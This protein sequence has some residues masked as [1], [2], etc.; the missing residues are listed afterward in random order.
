[1]K[2]TSLLRVPVLSVFTSLMLIVGTASAQTVQQRLD[3]VSAH[4]KQLKGLAARM[5]AGAKEKLSASAQHQ[6]RLALQW[7]QMQTGVNSAA[8]NT[9]LTGSR[10]HSDSGRLQGDQVSDPSTDLL[11]SRMAGFTQS[12]TSTAWCGSH[13]LV[14]FND[15][16]SFFETFPVPGIGLSFNGYSLSTDA[17][18]SFTDLGYLNPGPS[19]SNFLEGDPVAVCTDDKTFYQSSIFATATTNDVSV[20]KSTDGGKTFG[21]PVSAVSK[22]FF[23]HL[24]DKPWMAADPSNPKK[25]YVSYSD[26]DFT[27]PGLCGDGF[28]IGIELVRSIDGGAHWSSP[29]IV[30]TSCFPDFDQGSTVAVDGSGRVYVA[31][32]RFPAALPTN[33]I[34]IARST[35]GGASFAPKV[36]AQILMPVGSPFFGLLQGGFRNNEFPALAIDLS[37]GGN[38]SIYMTWNDGRFGVTLDN[39]PFFGASTYNFGDALVSRSDDGGRN[40]SAAVKV[41]DN[42]EGGSTRA[43][44]Y[45]PGIAVDRNGAVGVCFYDRRRDPTNFFIDRECAGSRDGGRTWKNHRVTRASFPPSISGDLLINPVYMGDYDGMASDSTGAFD[46]FLG[47]YGDNSRGNPDV[48]I[49]KRFRGTNNEGDDGGQP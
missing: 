10:N 3:A 2:R 46:G 29:K 49:S 26:F 40:W 1:M 44:H 42:E 9:P 13:V 30:E 17:G 6:L 33:E 36:V 23:F 8:R 38:G 18:Q 14:A 31:W 47:A 21:D 25:L 43:D 7:D 34:D 5:P 28:R 32:E 48:K 16:G 19:I 22:D 39:F 27:F 24:L 45:L 41:N 11:Y 35:D 15:S 12:E 37:N 20:S 4:L